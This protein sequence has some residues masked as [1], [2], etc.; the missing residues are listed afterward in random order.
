M[1]S[2]REKIVGEETV[3]R[4]IVRGDIM[5]DNNPTT[6]ITQYT[7]ANPTPAGGGN[8]PAPQPKKI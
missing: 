4:D 5:N 2:R 6:P 8:P 7:L 1:E 3:E